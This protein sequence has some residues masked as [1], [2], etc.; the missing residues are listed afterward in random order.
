VS[1][2]IRT[3]QDLAG[4]QLNEVAFVMDY[5]EFHFNGPVL[6]AISNPVVQMADGRYEFPQSGSRDALC[7]LISR[8][9]LSIRLAEGSSIELTLSAGAKVTIPLDEAHR[10]GAEAAHFQSQLINS[11]IMFVW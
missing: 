6:R 2:E 5:V 4:R 8:D 1:T 10:R 3:I 11:P 7:S 9:V